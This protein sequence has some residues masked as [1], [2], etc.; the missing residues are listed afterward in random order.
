MRNNK[1]G[2]EL[3]VRGEPVPGYLSRFIRASIFDADGT[4]IG[5]RYTL[6]VFDDPADCQ[7]AAEQARQQSPEE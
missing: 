2:V 5:V 4:R 7:A 3:T 1:A 6:V